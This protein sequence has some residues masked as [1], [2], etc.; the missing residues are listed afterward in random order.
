[1]LPL[2]QLIVPIKTGTKKIIRNYYFFVPI[3]LGRKNNR[4]EVNML[5][6]HKKGNKNID[7]NNG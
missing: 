6:Y 3:E 2:I 1:M 4:R 5:C 7:A